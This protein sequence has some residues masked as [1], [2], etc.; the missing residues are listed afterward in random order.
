MKLPKLDNN[1][2]NSVQML[3]ILRILKNN[4]INIARRRQIF[5]VMCH[6]NL[7]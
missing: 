1:G 6:H 4:E 3:L 2:H 5:I 7:N